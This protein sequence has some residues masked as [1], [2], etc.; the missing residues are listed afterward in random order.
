MS[1]LD[2]KGSAIPNGINVPAGKFF[3]AG[4]A[5][6]PSA[7]ELNK[8]KDSTFTAAQLEGFIKSLATI[9]GLNGG[10]GQKAIPINGIAQ[11]AGG[12]GIA[13]MTI[14]APAPG[15]LVVIRIA[16]IT[17]GTVVVTSAAGV[18]FDGTNNTATFNAADD[19]LILVYK[20]ATEWSIVLNAGAVA[21]SSV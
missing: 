20:S 11:I 3:I 13:D 19:A 21:L 16:S 14:A 9:T 15:S 5:V 1:G 12:T 6:T 10:A 8:L 4:V 7:A 17:S 18:T 2:G